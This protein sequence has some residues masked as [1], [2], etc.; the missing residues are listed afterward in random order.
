MDN[1]EPQTRYSIRAVDRALRILMA[2]TAQ[3]GELTIGELTAAAEVPRSTV[4]RL[5]ATLEI[6]GF[7]ERGSQPDTY[8]LGPNALLVG[9][10]ALRQVNFHDRIRPHLKQLMHETGETV[11]LVIFRSNQAIVL[12]KIDSQHAI[13]LVSNIGYQSPLH[14]SA[15]GKL[16]LAFQPDDVI[17][18]VLN[19]YV[20]TPLTP[21]TIADPQTLLA[22]LQQ[23]RKQQFSL[24]LEEVELGLRCIAA[25]VYNFSGEVA[26]GVS[27]SGPAHR[28]TPAAVE[29]F[30][31]VVRQATARMSQ[32]LGFVDQSAVRNL[33]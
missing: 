3:K 6:G 8:R 7:V 24:D 28:I 21:N 13:Q 33:S 30:V 9:G 31:P 10:A 18:E 20:Y 1:S 25:P 29:K 12:D 4:F 26:A 15:A 2:F 16:L 23:I 17:Q 14:A 32:D 19:G 27:M 22:H 11:H 5:L